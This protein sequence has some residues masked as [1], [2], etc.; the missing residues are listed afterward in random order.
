MKFRMIF[1]LLAMTLSASLSA[2]FGGPSPVVT[3][4]ARMAAIAPTIQVAGTVISRS[5]AV[6]SSEVEGRLM[7]IVEVGTRVEAG[8]VLAQIEDTVVLLRKQELEGEITRA[9]SRPAI[10]A[11]RA[12][13]WG[14]CR[15]N[16]T[17]PASVRHLP[18]SWSNA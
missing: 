16:S 3:D 7:Q 15:L 8:D 10:C 5:D 9:M 6:L 1:G 13:A 18:V 14:K 17:A 2:Q 12:A 4:Q 11:S